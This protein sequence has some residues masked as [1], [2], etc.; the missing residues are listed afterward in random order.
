HGKKRTRIDNTSEF[1]HNIAAPFEKPPK[2]GEL[3]SILFNPF[4]LKIPLSPALYN[5]CEVLC[6]DFPFSEYFINADFFEETNSNIETNCFP[7][8]MSNYCNI[9]LQG[10]AIGSSEYSRVCDWDN[11][12][13]NPTDVFRKRFK[14]EHLWESDHNTHDTL[15]TLA[16][17]RSDYWE[18]FDDMRIWNHSIYGSLEYILAYAAA[19]S[20]LQFFAIDSSLNQT[21]ISTIL[22]IEHLENRVK[23]LVNIINIHCIL[24]SMEPFLPQD[25]VPVGK[26]LKR[27]FGDILIMNVEVEKRINM[28]ANY[29]FS[30]I[31]V[32]KD[33]YRKTK[34]IKFL[35]HAVKGPE[36]KDN[37]YKVILAPVGIRQVPKSEPEAKVAIHCILD[38]LIALHNLGYVHRDIRWPNIMKLV[39]DNWMLI[40]LECS[41]I[42]G[43]MVNFDPLADWAPEAIETHSYTKKA[44]I[45]MVGKLLSKLLCPL[46]KEAHDF[47][48]F[49]T[50]MNLNLRPTAEEALQHTWFS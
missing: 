38:A 7:E 49:T 48:R 18:H 22:D 4:S 28:F 30:N 40:D 15:I 20:Y 14:T 3:S 23:A 11:L 37:I 16:G 9:A 19:G 33:I 17:L 43:E 13:R 26:L 47:E 1:C 46:S 29:P 10:S 34:E 6:Q 39:D 5:K 32:L 35:I 36:I 2:I 45:Y 41:G 25:A 12:L 8:E 44:D 24:R 42:N 50:T 27:P 21:A 31:N